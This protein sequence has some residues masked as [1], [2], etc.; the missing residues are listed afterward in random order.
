MYLQKL[1][2]VQAEV[3]VGL[4]SA[5]KYLQKLLIVQAAADAVQR[6]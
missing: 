3:D 1:L 5:G 4:R 6:L 2:F